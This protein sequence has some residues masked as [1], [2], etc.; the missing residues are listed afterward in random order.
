M[1]LVKWE[2]LES[3]MK[4][5]ISGIVQG[6]R[7]RYSFLPLFF[8]STIMRGTAFFAERNGPSR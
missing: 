2:T 5:T 8:I 7:S 6:A 3:I 1:E 4:N